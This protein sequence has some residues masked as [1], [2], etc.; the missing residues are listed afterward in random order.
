MNKSTTR[1]Y[2]PAFLTLC[3]SYTLFS[4]SFNMIIPELPSYLSSLGGAD[5]KGLI[6][7]LFTLTAGI[8]RP[9]SGKLAD[10]VGRI[11]VIYV[12]IIVCFVC[13]LLYPI[14]TS[15][16]GFLLLRLVHG[17]STGFSPTATTAYVADAVPP[18]RRGEAMGILGVCMNTGASIA[19]PIGSWLV[20]E[21]SL[22]T[23][24]FASSGVALVSMLILTQLKETLPEKK[25]F[26]WRIL[27]LKRNEI[28]EKS[29]FL[30]AAICLTAYFGF[31]VIVT[32]VPDQSE[33]LGIANKGLFFTAL[34]LLSL[35]SRLVAGKSSDIYGRIPVM[36]IA[37]GLLALS[38]IFM[39]FV[40]TPTQLM[41]ASGCIG[42]SHGIAGP[43]VFALAIDRAADERRAR[44]MATLYIGLEISI[45]TGALFGAYSYDNNPDNYGITFLF[46]AGVTSLAFLLLGIRGK[47]LPFSRVEAS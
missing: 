16:A 38:Y 19:P 8:S 23:L 44:A 46:V 6:I 2:T 5:Y 12:G 28:F 34:T 3:L 36:R 37:M 27:K 14:L 17:F 1:L 47:K 31:G 35:T 7:A 18:N 20:L 10:T 22:N 30:P 42:F 9:F 40:S 26:H 25:P 21:F 39:S 4:A 13:S 24:F 29:A 15:V 33:Y 43:A 32:I 11:P 41:L 45:G